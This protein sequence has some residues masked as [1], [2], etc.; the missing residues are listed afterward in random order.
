MDR[1]LLR[2][3]PGLR[4]PPTKSRTTHAEVGTGQQARTRNYTLNITSADP[5]IGSSLTTCDLASHD[6]QQQNVDDASRRLL[7]EAKQRFRFSGAHV[8]SSGQR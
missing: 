7:P 3:S 5:P 2:L 4:T 6:D 8:P 1:P